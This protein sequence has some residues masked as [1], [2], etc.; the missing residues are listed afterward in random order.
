MNRGLAAAA[1]AALLTVAACG[2]GGVAGNDDTVS[3]DCA[4]AFGDLVDSLKT[5]DSHLDI[6]L[7]YADYGDQLGDVKAA[8][9]DVDLK[10]LEPGCT[11]AIGVD[12]EDALNHYITA[13]G[14]WRDC[15]KDTA[16]KTDSI[17]GDLQAEWS[18]A[19]TL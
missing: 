11:A 4:A 6:G 3:D 8:Y 18:A 17:Q 1:V 15:I 16:C 19:S 5:I 14:F 9:D 7:T 13:Y 2:G 10:N 12:A